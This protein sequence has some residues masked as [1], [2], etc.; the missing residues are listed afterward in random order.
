MR[1]ISLLL[2]IATVAL[3]HAH[4]P[5]PIWSKDKANNWYA[6]KGWLRGCDFIPSTAINQLEMWQSDA[7]DPATIDKELG[8]A[9]SIGLNCMRVFLHHVAWQE[10]HTGFKE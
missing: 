1:I 10:D 3:I 7:F 2:A 4:S 6:T 5:R 9:Q 8:F